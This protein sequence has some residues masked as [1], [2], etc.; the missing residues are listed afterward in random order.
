MGKFL[1]CFIGMMAQRGVGNFE[2]SDVIDELEK[3]VK[4]EEN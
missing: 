1:G 4:W 2:N 3:K